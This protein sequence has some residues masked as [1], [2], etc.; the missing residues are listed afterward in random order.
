MP[1]I[2]HFFQKDQLRGFRGSCCQSSSAFSTT[3]SCDRSVS[4]AA[5]FSQSVRPTL[6]SSGMADS[7]SPPRYSDFSFVGLGGTS[8]ELG[9]D[10]FS[11]GTCVLAV[12]WEP[13][14]PGRVGSVADGSLAMSDGGRRGQGS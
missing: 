10:S 12:E 3:S 4:P 9:R 6:R 5:E 2:A 1:V 14:V 7:P 11:V 13:A 8:C